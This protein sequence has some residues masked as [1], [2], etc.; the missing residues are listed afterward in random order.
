MGSPISPALCGMVI[1]S[2]EECWMQCYSIARRSSDM[3]C[4]F[5][6]YVD[7]RLLFMLRDI[8]RQSCLQLLQNNHVYGGS[9]ELEDEA[10]FDCLG[11]SLDH[12]H[13]RVQYNRNLVLADLLDVLSAAP[14]TI[15]LSVV[16]S[17]AHIIKMCSFPLTQIQDDLQFLWDVARERGLPVHSKKFKRKFFSIPAAGI[18]HSVP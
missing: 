16:L 4:L 8:S 1:A 12:E 7:S 15:L 6:R 11:F 18:R 14:T 3:F 2:L 17:R 5:L 9:T 13:G 10:E